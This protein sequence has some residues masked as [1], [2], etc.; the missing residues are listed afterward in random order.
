MKDLSYGKEGLF[1]RFYANTPAGVI[2]YNVIAQHNNGVGV[3]FSNHLTATLRQLRSSGLS[4]GAEKRAKVS[5]ADMD[6]L[7]TGLM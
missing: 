3:I 5:D 4:V 1:V 6:K 7:L 2:A